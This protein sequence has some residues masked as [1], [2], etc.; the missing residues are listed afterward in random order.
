MDNSNFD[1]SYGDDFGLGEV[2]EVVELSRDSMHLGLGSGQTLEPFLNLLAAEVA[3]GDDVLHFVGEEQVS[4]L[5][6]H[7]GRPLR[8]MNVSDD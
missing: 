1:V 4:E 5:L 3:R 8:D 6:S 2:G 7:L